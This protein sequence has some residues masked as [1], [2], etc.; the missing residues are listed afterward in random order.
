M[1]SV[2]FLMD[3]LEGVNVAH[4]STFALMLEAQRR[5]HRVLY[6]EQRWLRWSG[7]EVRAHMREVRVQREPG[8]HFLVLREE[9]LPLTALDVLFLRKDPPVD[10]EFLHATQLVELV[11]PGQGPVMINRPA[12]LRGANE[13]LFALRFPDLMP[14]TL[15]SSE[16]GALMEFADAQPE[17]TILKPVDGFGGQGGV[18]VGP[19]DRNARSL[20]ELLT[21]GGRECVIA[22]AYVPQ[23]RAG[24]KRIVLVDG[25]P[26]GAVL[27]VPKETEHRGNMAV[28]G[29]PD[30]TTLTERERAICARLAPALREHGLYLV[31][32]DVLGDFLTEVNVTSPTGLVEIAQLDGVS[33]E[34][35]V[36]DLAERLAS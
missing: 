13:K 4:D 5:G 30:K 10:A 35:H 12:G 34:A 22:Q 16:L 32:I 9:V 7:G 14:T 28:G 20:A 33:V 21:R 11:P 8:A 19:R 25:E 17:G 2:G 3:P 15:V 26:V 29:R 27:R 23:A 6:F 31:G 36:V 24:D 1:L 18:F